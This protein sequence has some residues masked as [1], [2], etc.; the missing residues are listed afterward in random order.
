MAYHERESGGN[1]FD[2]Y[3]EAELSWMKRNNKELPRKEGATLYKVRYLPNLDRTYHREIPTHYIPICDAFARQQIVLRCLVEY[4]FTSFEIYHQMS[5][6]T[7]SPRGTRDP[8]AMAYY[9]NIPQT[10]L[11]ET[12]ASLVAMT[13]SRPRLYYHFTTSKYLAI[14]PGMAAS[15]QA[16]GVHQ[17]FFLEC[18]RI[19]LR[20]SRLGSQ[21]TQHQLTHTRCQPLDGYASFVRLP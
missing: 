10:T 17:L 7:I 1:T 2:G 12:P 8:V 15:N 18:W 6:I 21:V 4:I 13:P 3:N 20:T 14:I 19:S 9:P 5:R 11:V 16:L